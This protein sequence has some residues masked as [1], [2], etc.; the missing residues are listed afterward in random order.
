[1][2]LFL[3]GP[4]RAAGAP[5]GAWLQWDAGRCGMRWGHSGA[6][7]HLL[8]SICAFLQGEKG[9]RGEKVSGCW[10]EDGA[11]PLLPS[12]TLLLLHFSA[13]RPWGMCV[14]PQPTPGPQPHWDAGECHGSH[15]HSHN[16]VPS[17]RASLLS[18]GPRE[19]QDSGLGHP[20]SPSRVPRWVQSL[21]VAQLPAH[22]ASLLISLPVLGCCRVLLEHL[23]PPVLLVPRAAR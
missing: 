15:P 5:R 17:H 20:G 8:T 4:R 16:S 7:G 19:L 1:M 12:T 11:A 6:G 21:R 2:L 13:G 9:A 22:A 23:V 10:G 14:P 18:L 3:S